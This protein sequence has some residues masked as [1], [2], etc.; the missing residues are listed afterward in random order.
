[1][2]AERKRARLRCKKSRNQSIATGA[3]T[4]KC[5]GFRLTQVQLL[6][7]SCGLSFLHSLNIVHGDLKGVRLGFFLHHSRSVGDL[8]I[9]H[10]RRIS[11]STNLVVRDSAISV[12]KP[13]SLSSTVPR[14]S[15]L[16]SRD[17]TDGWR[18]SSLTSTA[19]GDLVSPRANR[20]SLLWEWLLLR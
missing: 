6:D 10:R 4:R 14:P 19:E 3:L 9:P 11:S 2:D 15:R 1:M 20:T 5:V 13:T 7:I 16:G 17:P 12:S 8:T 18:P